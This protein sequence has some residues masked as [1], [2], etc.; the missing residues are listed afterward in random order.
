[1]RIDQQELRQ[2]IWHTTKDIFFSAVREYEAAL[3]GA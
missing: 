1:M 2:L 3:H